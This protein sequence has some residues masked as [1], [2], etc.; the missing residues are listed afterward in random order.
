MAVFFVSC[1]YVSA[2]S[3]VAEKLCLTKLFQNLCISQ[4]KSLSEYS[5]SAWDKSASFAEP[6]YVF[7]RWVKPS[8]SCL[9]ILCALSFCDFKVAVFSVALK[10]FK[11]SK[12]DFRC[13]S[14][15]KGL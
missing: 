10:S 8:T 6:I 12:A 3:Y 9:A 15:I 7:I 4:D 5:V 1:G 14:S 2:R 11:N 13:I